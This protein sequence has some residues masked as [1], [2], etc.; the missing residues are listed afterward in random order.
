M[1]VLVVGA[2]AVGQVYGYHLQKGGADVTF[3]V[4]AKYVADIKDGLT[5]YPLN[6]K[7]TVQM[8]GF[9]TI[10]E[11]AQ[12]AAVKWDYVIITTSSTA[13]YTPWLA[14]FL[15]ATGESTIVTLQPGMNDRAELLKFL[16]PARLMDGFITLVSYHAPLPGENREPGMA[17]WFPPMTK[18][19][20]KGTDT[21]VLPLLEVFKRGEFPCERAQGEQD[22]LIPATV[23]SVA[24]L[25]LEAADWKFKTFLEPARMKVTS[26]ALQETME[27]VCRKAKIKPP[28]M[29]RFLG[30]TF[31][32]ALF[33]ASRYVIPFDF[34]VYL[35]V[36]FTKVG[37]QM[38]A[39]IANYLQA[40][41]ELDVKMPALESLVESIR[42]S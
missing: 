22:S 15:G 26:K 17:Y 38:R 28:L 10:S 8:K 41:R 2:G 30:R 16:P 29:T 35:Q 11:T 40:G 4:R 21:Q 14:E 33:G 36:H 27:V 23:L 6:T 13:L 1:R 20:L 25:A 37:D 7:T 34:E 3:Y 9:D 39:G 42:V 32:C 24:V 31:F 19:G 5:L 18:A 12:V